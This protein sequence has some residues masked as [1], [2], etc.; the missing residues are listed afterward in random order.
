MDRFQE[1][2]VFA[3]IAERSSFTQAAD[4]LQLPRATVSNLIQRLGMLF[5]TGAAKPAE[6]MNLAT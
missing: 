1:M 5:K 3:R 6:C 4:D 2:Q